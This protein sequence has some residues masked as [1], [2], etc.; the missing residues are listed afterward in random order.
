MPFISEFYLFMFKQPV[1]HKPGTKILYEPGHLKVRHVLIY[2][3]ECM[4]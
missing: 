3:I 2:K 4:L 1:S